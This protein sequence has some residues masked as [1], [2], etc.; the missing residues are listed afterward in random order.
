MSSSIVSPVRRIQQ[1]ALLHSAGDSACTVETLFA[2]HR[3]STLRRCREKHRVRN[4]NL[5]HA[6]SESGSL[7]LTF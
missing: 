1:C 7:A 6:D 3:G 2:L 4:L 5:L